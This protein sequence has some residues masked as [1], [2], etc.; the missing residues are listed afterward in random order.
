E[1]LVAK[2]ALAMD[3]AAAL[4]KEKSKPRRPENECGR[5]RHRERHWLDTPASETDL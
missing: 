2:E 4:L 3:R 1:M 5:R